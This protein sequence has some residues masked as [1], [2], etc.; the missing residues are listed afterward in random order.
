ML[1]LPDYRWAQLRETSRQRL[2]ASSNISSSNAV[3]SQ[4]P[5]VRMELMYCVPS[6]G[7]QLGERSRSALPNIQPPCTTKRYHFVLLCVNG[8]LH[9]QLCVRC[10]QSRS[11]LE[12]L[13]PSVLTGS[14]KAFHSDFRA[15]PQPMN[16][17]ASRHFFYCNTLRSFG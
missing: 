3:P 1:G 2:A 16:S 15:L 11:L 10:C 12:L 14:W 13:S 8:S 4:G 5:S 6:K 17:K 9:S 7:P